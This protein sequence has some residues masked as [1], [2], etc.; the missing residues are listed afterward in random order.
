MHPLKRQCVNGL[1]VALLGLL[2]LL[3]G[4]ASGSRITLLPDQDGHVGAVTVSTAK[5]QQRIDEAYGS[6]FVASADAAPRPS[7][8]M[9]PQTFEQAHRALLDAQP[10]R[11]CSF[12]LNFE[13]DSVELTP[14]SRKMLPEIIRA[15]H[16]HMPTEV[17]VAG[18]ADEAGTPEHNLVL[19]AQRARV[20]AA[21]L[22]KSVQDVPVE[23]QYFGDKHP[24]VPSHRG[25]R[26]PRNRRAEIFVL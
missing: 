23:V 13:F 26:E 8:G 21:L 3:A 12:M 16:D 7:P 11:S 17:T 1:T 5:G 6:V 25:A 24:L 15:V 9:D 4:C 14:K 19:S 2:I 22:K 20:V 10:P 18:Y